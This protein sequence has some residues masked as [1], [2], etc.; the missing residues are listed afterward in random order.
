MQDLDFLDI[1]SSSGGQMSS[2]SDYIKV[3]Q[4]ILDPGRP[5]SLLPPYVVREW[6]RPLHVWSDETTE[7][8]MLWEIEK[9]ADTY[10][11]QLRIYQKRKWL[12]LS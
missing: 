4:M 1:M 8:G 7:V 3:M 2:L 10:G 11:R 9:I 12:W 6:L 5:G